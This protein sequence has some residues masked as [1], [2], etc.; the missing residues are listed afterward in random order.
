M[1][2]SYRRAVRLI[3][4]AAAVLVMVAGLAPASAGTVVGSSAPRL[5]GAVTYVAADGVFT[6][7]LAEVDP[8][9]DV[10]YG[11]V[12]SPWG[13]LSFVLSNVPRPD[14]GCPRCFPQDDPS[15]GDTSDCP[16]NNTSDP[17]YARAVLGG[18]NAPTRNGNYVQ[19]SVTLESCTSQALSAWTKEDLG[20][21]GNSSQ[22]FRID[23]P[24]HRWIS[25]NINP[26]ACDE[27]AAGSGKGYYYYTYVETDAGYGG[28]P[29][30]SNESDSRKWVNC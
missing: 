8:L 6:V 10:V 11:T 3:T 9:L 7:D 27:A 20:V 5:H 1:R 14:P 23:A 25:M 21:S 22:R 4:G 19:G 28:E 29:Y 16:D 18:A 30:W 12:P 15:G 24:A 26:V 13:E 2:M 17:N